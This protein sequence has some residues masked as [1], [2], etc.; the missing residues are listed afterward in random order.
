MGEECRHCGNYKAEGTVCDDCFPRS[1]DERRDDR[2]RE[3]FNSD[4]E[5]Y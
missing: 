5:P 3:G 4:G 2:L 1:E